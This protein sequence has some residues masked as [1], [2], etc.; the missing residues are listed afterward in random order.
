MPVYKPVQDL[1]TKGSSDRPPSPSLS[2]NIEIMGTPQV[3]RTLFTSP[4]PVSSESALAVLAPFATL[5]SLVWRIKR[6]PHMR[7]VPLKFEDYDH[8][9]V[10]SNYML[11]DLDKFFL[12]E[13][14]EYY[15]KR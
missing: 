7:K 12:N 2:V 4:V 14:K 11:S 9:I 13:F 15:E 10:H 5:D 3:S 1:L 6:L 8:S